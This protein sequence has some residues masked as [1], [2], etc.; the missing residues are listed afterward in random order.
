MNYERAWNELE[1]EIGRD[2]CIFLGIIG[3]NPSVADMAAFNTMKNVKGTMQRIREK[4]A[5]E[6]A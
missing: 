1:D 4:Y 2:I 3:G 6:E 5:E